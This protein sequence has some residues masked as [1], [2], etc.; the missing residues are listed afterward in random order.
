[1]LLTPGQGA[2]IERPQRSG[3]EAERLKLGAI[4]GERRG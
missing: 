1:L 3:L 2:L 4:G